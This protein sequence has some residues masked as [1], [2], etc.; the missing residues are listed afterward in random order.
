[1]TNVGF[2]V[3]V[4][5]LAFPLLLRA[6]P[7]ESSGE[8]DGAIVV[9][10]CARIDAIILNNNTDHEKIVALTDC[11]RI[12]DDMKKVRERLRGA[13][14][15][16]SGALGDDSKCEDFDCRVRVGSKRGKV[17]CIWYFPLSGGKHC[18]IGD[19]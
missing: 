13:R 11:V 9:D 5:F 4:V 6:S 8:L 12:G 17:T 3:V 19:W 1:M 18:L 16:A 14:C 2:T 10:W 7:N 15:I